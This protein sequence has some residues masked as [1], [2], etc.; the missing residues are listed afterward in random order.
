MGQ[1]RRLGLR[2]ALGGV[3]LISAE[4]AGHNLQMARNVLFLGLVLAES[5]SE[6]DTILE[7]TVGRCRRPGQ[8]KDVQVYNLASEAGFGRRKAEVACRCPTSVALPGRNS[9]RCSYY[10]GPLGGPTEQTR[11]CTSVA[12]PRR[13]TGL[14]R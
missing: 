13:K 9:T 10:G 12:M 11:N 7:Q 1:I 3:M 8:V 4:A 14:R 2:M 5:V 6:R